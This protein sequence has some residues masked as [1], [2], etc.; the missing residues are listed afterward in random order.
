MEEREN[1]LSDDLLIDPV[2]GGYLRESASW[3]KVTAI[4]GFII[5]IFFFIFVYQYISMLT[6]SRSVFRRSGPSGQEK[7]TAVFYVL[8][9]IIH[10]ALS[11]LQFKYAGNMQN[12]LRNND[13]GSL[14]AAFNNLKIFSL[15]RM[16][17]AILVVIMFALILVALMDKQSF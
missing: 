9:G 5:S 1:I 8:A 2:S 17:V 12:A 6:E 11:F 15:I 13:Q 7:L 16:I 14:I 4:A 10:F 3:S